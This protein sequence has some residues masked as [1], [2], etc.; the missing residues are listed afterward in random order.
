MTRLFWNN[1][2]TERKKEKKETLAFQVTNY[3]LDGG[4]LPE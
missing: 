2:K 4:E 3:A 1:K